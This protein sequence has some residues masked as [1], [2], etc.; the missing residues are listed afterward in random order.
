VTL[1]A[2]PEAAQVSAQGRPR[3]PPVV[4][5]DGVDLWRVDLDCP[6]QPD[7]R[8]WLSASE[9]DRA[10]RFVF[11]RDARRYRAAHAHLRVLLWQQCGWPAATEFAIGAFGKPSL[12]RTSAFRFN[13]SDSGPQAL[14]GIGKGR[15]I[16]VDI[17]VLRTLDDIG[18]LAEQNFSADE[19]GDLRALSAGEVDHAFL[20]VWTRKEAC[21]KAVGCG[22]SVAPARFTVGLGSTAQRVSVPTERGGVA[23]SVQSVNL[24]P[25]LVVAVARALP[26]EAS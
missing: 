13:L 1:A 24:E 14:I 17:E 12:G 8:L 9:H 20:T 11:E 18:T 22:L 21:L 26:A 10:A 19:L 25:E 7:P 6:R 5:V 4:S 15:D 23:V 3:V 2:W 16:G